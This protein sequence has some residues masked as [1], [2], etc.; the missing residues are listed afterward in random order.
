MEVSLLLKYFKLL[1]LGF[2]L[3]V[4]G[5]FQILPC[6]SKFSLEKLPEAIVNQS[7]LQKIEISGG[8]MPN[9][10]NINWEITPEHS[11]L[12]ITRFID[13]ESG[14]YGGVDI[15][16]VPNFQGDITIHLYGFGY[17]YRCSFDRTLVIKVNP[18]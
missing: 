15:S 11:G 13:K 14:L 17:G 3:L 7:Y 18:E 8:A 2:F 9:E 4:S 10:S 12:L 5:C 1:L 16:G 6:E